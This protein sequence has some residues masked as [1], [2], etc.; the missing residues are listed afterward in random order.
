VAA[1]GPR[2][3][4]VARA[5]S[6]N[7]RPCALEPCLGGFAKGRRSRCS[8]QPAAHLA[9]GIVAPAFRRALGR[10][11]LAYLLLVP[12]AVDLRLPGPLAAARRSLA[13]VAVTLTSPDLRCHH[14]PP[15]NR[16]STLSPSSRQSA[17]AISSVGVVPPVSIRAIVERGEPILSPSA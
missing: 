11:Q 2:L 7:T 1:N 6:D 17:S 10:E 3:V 9:L 4:R 13:A 5:V 14:S 12:R 8:Q 15:P 16:L